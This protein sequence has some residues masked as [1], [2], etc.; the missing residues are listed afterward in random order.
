MIHIDSPNS[1]TYQ[2]ELS[3]FDRFQILL[4]ISDYR[5]RYLTTNSTQQHDVPEYHELNTMTRLY[6]YDYTYYVELGLGEFD[7]GSYHSI[8]LIV[9]TGSPVTW[10]QCEGCRACFTQSSPHFPRSRS[11]TYRQYDKDHCM[12]H[13][14][15]TDGMDLKGFWAREKLTFVSSIAEE[16]IHE[17]VFVCGIEITNFIPGALGMGRGQSSLLTQLGTRGNYQFSYCLQHFNN[18]A[19]DTYIRFG[20]AIQR[21]PNMFSTPLVYGGIPTHYYVSLIDI[22]VNDKRLNLPQHL[23]QAKLNNT[24][25]TV[26]DT[27]TILTYLVSEAFDIV[28]DEIATYVENYNPSL[29][30]STNLRG[31]DAPCWEAIFYTP[32]VHFPP[33]IFHFDGYADL[34][35]YPSNVM[36]KASHGAHPLGKYCATLGRVQPNGWDINII[37]S[38]YQMNQLVIFDVGNSLLLFAHV[39]CN[40]EV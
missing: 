10:T 15:Y 3:D 36:I 30:K 39:D 24:G 32:D 6:K 14:T 25:G 5:M 11:Q 13:D 7:G 18:L 17:F 35:I 40:I 26:F 20:D 23:F 1:P 4:A 31:S 12:F 37:G 22:S 16:L 27:G 34:F 28:V 21:L 19:S 2:P 9:D 38:I 29:R 33:L 8:F